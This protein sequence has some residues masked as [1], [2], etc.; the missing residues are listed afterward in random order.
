MSNIVYGLPKEP[1]EEILNARRTIIDDHEKA[2]LGN[3][4]LLKIVSKQDL[5]SVL[6]NLVAFPQVN[7]VYNHV[8]RS[9]DVE[10]IPP[11]KKW[12]QE[13]LTYLETL[14]PRLRQG[15]DYTPIT[16]ILTKWLAKEKDKEA[17]LYLI[18]EVGLIILFLPLLLLWFIFRDSAPKSPARTRTKADDIRRI[19]EI[20]DEKESLTK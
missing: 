14:P 17:E 13:K 5:L 12:Y 20:L 15:V 18:I 4:K 16:R 7:Y 8:T 3:N 2:V 9:T 1:T 10:F 11:L 6:D 19:R